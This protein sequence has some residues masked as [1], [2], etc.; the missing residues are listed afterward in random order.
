MGAC[1]HFRVSE[2][3]GVA[4]F[5]QNEDDAS[6]AYI[7]RAIVAEKGLKIKAGATIGN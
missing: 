5:D 1:S 3:K 6:L 2:Q 7:V 4:A